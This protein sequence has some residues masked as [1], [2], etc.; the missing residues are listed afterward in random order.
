[1]PVP[2]LKHA[3]DTLA[4][5]PI[6]IWNGSSFVPSGVLGSFKAINKDKFDPFIGLSC[7]V[8]D[9]FLSLGSGV[10]QD[11]I[12]SQ[13]WLIISS[14]QH[15]HRGEAYQ[16]HYT[17]LKAVRQYQVISLSNNPVSKSGLSYGH[18]QVDKSETIEYTTYSKL[19]SKPSKVDTLI[20]NTEN[21]HY[22][23]YLDIKLA[24]P[25]RKD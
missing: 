12:T 13:I 5:T 7:S 4:K 10:I 21:P 17:L 14:N 23:F 2:S 3:V 18:E 1:M 25:Q 19:I 20:K 22:I 24:K 15:V 11:S 8:G 16:T 6:N 9:P